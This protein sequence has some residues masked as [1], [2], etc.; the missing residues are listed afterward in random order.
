VPTPPYSAEEILGA[1]ADLDPSAPWPDFI[2]CFKEEISKT[3]YRQARRCGNTSKD[4][5]HDLVQQMYLR[6]SDP[7]YRVLAKFKAAGPGSAYAYIHIVAKNFVT[8]FFKSRFAKKHGGKILFFAP[9]DTDVAMP[10]G[11]QGTASAMD[12]EVLF[13]QVDKCLHMLNKGPTWDRDYKIFWDYYRE[14][15]S[16][17]EIAM[18][19]DIGLTAEGVESVLLRMVRGVRELLVDGW[20]N[21]TGATG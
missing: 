15:M 13:A 6:L 7:Q 19:P 16:A 8:D 18:V 14:G 17:R 1:C 21:P 20:I 11:K 5:V 12:R 9:E 3:V 4:L 10:E 2:S